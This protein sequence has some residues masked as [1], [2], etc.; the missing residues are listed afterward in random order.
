MT[1]NALLRRRTVLGAAALGPILAY[2]RATWAQAPSDRPLRFVLPMA[3]GSV[4]DTLAR[5]MAGHLTQSLKRPVVVENLPGAGGM[6]GTAQLVRAPADGSTLALV[7]TSHV[8]NPFVFKAMPYDPIKDVTPIT[9]IGKSMMVLV[10]NPAMP[11][12]NFAEF[13]RLLKASPG[14][15]NYGSSGNGGV[16][17]LPAEMLN[18]EAGVSAR[19]IPYKGLSAQ[20]TDIIAGVVDYGFVPVGV[21]VP[22]LKAGKLRALAVT[23]TVRSP[24]LSQVAT[25]K[26]SG[27]ASYLYEPWLAIIGPAG[28]TAAQTQALYG[29]VRTALEQKEMRALM[30]AQDMTPVTM[31]PEETSTYFRSEM[32]TYGALA[33]YAGLRAE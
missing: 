11:A 18:R 17:H 13:I 20:V 2:R 29:D 21:A 27:L 7:S 26:E 15:F 16:T 28:L 10:V 19:H 5:G 30:D 32:L 9:V 14:K 12:Q 23:G 6:T 31:T 3:A 1:N 33:K 22:H 8:I 25:I 4:G 24:L